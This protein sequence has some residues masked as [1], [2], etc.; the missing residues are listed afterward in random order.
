MF[1]R[2]ILPQGVLL[3]APQLPYGADFSFALAPGSYAVFAVDSTSIYGD[4]EAMARYAEKATK[5]TV[6]ANETSSVSV[7]VIPREK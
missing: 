6:S 5:V 4:F 1:I 2:R 3:P 7:D